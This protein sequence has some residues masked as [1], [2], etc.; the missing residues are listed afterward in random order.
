M[1]L[2]YTAITPGYPGTPVVP[3]DVVDGG[4]IHIPEA[5]LC[6]VGVLQVEV[7]QGLTIGGADA[8]GVLQL[9]DDN[10]AYGGDCALPLHI[11]TDLLHSYFYTLCMVYALY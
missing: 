2:I 1:N 3:E 8:V 6:A 11:Y 5:H 10:R 9:S 4:R 7:I